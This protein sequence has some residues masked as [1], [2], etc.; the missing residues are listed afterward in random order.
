MLAVATACLCLPGSALGQTEGNYLYNVT[1]LRAAPGHFSELRSV[2]EESL[3]IHEQA[4]D[5]APFW[6]RHSQGDQWDFM[7]IYPMGDYSSYYEADRIQSRA[8]AWQAGQGV[9]VSE[10]LSS[11]VSYREEWSARSVPVDEMARRFEGMGLFHVEMFAGL[12]GKR[13]ELLEQRRMENR[14]YGHLDRQQ[15]VLFVREAG[16][17]W[18]AMTIGFFADLSAFAAA[19]TLYSSAEQDKAARA[20]GFEGIDQVGPYLRSLIDYHH[21]TL[22]VS[23]R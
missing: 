6:L 22:A 4:G 11:L 17:N 21:D 20:A 5:A 3:A 7:L 8:A 2:L 15:N 1:M 16:S 14:Y 9:A 12:P 13:G 18:D 23:A 19:G 10:R